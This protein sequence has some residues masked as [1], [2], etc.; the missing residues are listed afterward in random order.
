L[1]HYT[2][3]AS[4]SDADNLDRLDA[5]KDDDAGAPGDALA[6]YTYLGL[7]TV[8]IQDYQEP[9]V[10]LDYFGGTSGAYAGF[11]PPSIV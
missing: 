9:Q 5:I 3:G 1:V 2:H 10:K 4:G 8:V 7:G 11:R 6:S